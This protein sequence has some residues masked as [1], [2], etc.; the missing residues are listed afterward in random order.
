MIHETYG[1]QAQF[2]LK[3]FIL[4]NKNYSSDMV[5]REVSVLADVLRKS[6]SEKSVSKAIKFA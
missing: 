5:I 2:F 6:F 4:N 1:G 3:Q